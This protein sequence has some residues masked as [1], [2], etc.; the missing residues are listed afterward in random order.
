MDFQKRKPYDQ[1]SDYIGVI[2]T[3]LNP[4]FTRSLQQS[5]ENLAN[6]NLHFIYQWC[7]A[8]AC[9]LTSIKKGG[10]CLY[11]MSPYYIA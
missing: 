2:Q 9:G 10:I 6:A 4:M 11:K 1:R 3:L 5:L 7:R 8:A